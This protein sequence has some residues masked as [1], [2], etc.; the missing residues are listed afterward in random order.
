MILLLVLVIPV[1]II[2][3]KIVK[4]KTEAEK[5]NGFDMLRQILI[6]V[7]GVSF[8]AW[9]FDVGTTYYVLDVLGA[10]TEQNPLGWPL[11]AL[12]ALIFYIPAIVFTYLLLF[13]IRKRYALWVAVL[14][15]GITLYLGLLNFIAGSQNFGFIDHIVPSVSEIYNYLFI[16]ILLGDIIFLF[17][18]PLI[19]LH[20]RTQL[21]SKQ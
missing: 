17:S 1:S 4:W 9:T 19:I 10:A 5:T 21:V 15:T 2:G 18:F 8:A 16:T 12:G 7:Y 13:K 11:G 14:I 6:S 20:K 3:Y